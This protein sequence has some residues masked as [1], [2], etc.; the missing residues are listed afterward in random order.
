MDADGEHDIGYLTKFK[1]KLKKKN[2]DLII[3]NRYH[4]NKF[5][6]KLFLYLQKENLILRIHYQDLNFIN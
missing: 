3:A 6:K 2:Y 5:L 4:K 1:K